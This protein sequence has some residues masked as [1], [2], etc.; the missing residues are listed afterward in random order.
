MSS[1]KKDSRDASRVSRYQYSE[2]IYAGNLQ[3]MTLG[4][5]TINGTLDVSGS[6]FI[7]GQ[8][9]LSSI[10][11]TS[12]ITVTG[13]SVGISLAST[14]T[15]GYLSSGNWTTFNNKENI[16]TFSTPLSR[17]A[18]AITIQQAGP[19]Q[20][21]YLSSTDWNTF[22]AGSVGLLT[23]NNTWSGIQIFSNLTMFNDIV[24]FNNTG[25]VNF[26]NTVNFVSLSEIPSADYLLGIDNTGKT[27]KTKQYPTGTDF[28]G[29]NYTFSTIAQTKALMNGFIYSSVFRIA[30]ITIILPYHNLLYSTFGN[31]TSF[32]FQLFDFFSGAAPILIDTSLFS[33]G[34]GLTSFFLNGVQS[35][36]F[37][38]T[39]FSLPFGAYQLYNVSVLVQRITSSPLFLDARYYFTTV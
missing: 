37:P 18:N 22:S 5:T 25:I 36:L 30:P 29:T 2:F 10:T 1:W 3:C 17:S 32:Q 24:N 7:N 12:P 9:V 35:G 28:N 14:S 4:N 21:G 38:A 15:D 8:P 33:N 16:L 20:A 34:T 19:T 11:A 23:S 26:N 39:S 31:I 6:I 13:N 27:F